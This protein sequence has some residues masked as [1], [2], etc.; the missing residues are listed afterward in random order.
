MR[1]S[2]QAE[3]LAFD[4]MNYF[5]NISTRNDAYYDTKYGVLHLW[6]KSNGWVFEY[7]KLE[8]LPEPFDLEVK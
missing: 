5:N 2:A 3:D 7:I 8:T 4:L 1:Y 6:W